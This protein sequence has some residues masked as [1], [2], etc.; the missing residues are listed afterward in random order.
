MPS[1]NELETKFPPVISDYELLNDPAAMIRLWAVPQLPPEEQIGK[2]IS[3]KNGWESQTIL[4]QQESDPKT[5]SIL[6]QRMQ[7]G[8]D[9]LDILVRSYGWYLFSFAWQR[10][11]RGLD[12]LELVDEG[13]KGLMEGIRKF[14][15][16]RG[17]HLSTYVTPWIKTK[18]D[19]AIREQTL[20]V[21]EPVYLQ[22]QRGHLRRGLDILTQE[23]QRY[24][25]ISEAETT[26]EIPQ[27]KLLFV[28]HPVN[29][30][31]SL[32]KPIQSDEASE[33][34]L[35]KFIADETAVNPEQALVEKEESLAVARA[36]QS[37]IEKLTPRQTRIFC[38]TYAIGENLEK[39]MHLPRSVRQVSKL[40]EQ[41]GIYIA[42]S[43]VNIDLQCAL[44]TLSETMKK[45]MEQP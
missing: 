16:K 18:M 23:L 40:L 25:K 19:R 20:T 41:E 35:E 26:L 21:Y 4:Q 12:V 29:Q 2:A 13:V 24:P 38:L 27:D 43:Q 1:T 37:A 6:K 28:L 17:Y 14:D 10:K 36:L 5:Q 15:P 11:D 7:E 9:A 8:A 42:H 44:E 45:T 32:D 39:D 31:Y 3:I 34:P 33:T 22:E 30:P